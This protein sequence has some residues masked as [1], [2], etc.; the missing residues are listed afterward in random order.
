MAF[1]KL[2]TKQL[3]TYN[4]ILL[5]IMILGLFAMGFLIGIELQ[6]ITEN[7]DSKIIYLVPTLLPL[8]IF[9]PLIFVIILQREIKKRRDGNV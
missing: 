6:R 5:G 7:V 2:T 1:E 9:V 8:H 4:K 3:K